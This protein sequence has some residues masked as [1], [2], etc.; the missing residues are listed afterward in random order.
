M[1]RDEN[2]ICELTSCVCGGGA[3]DH[4]YKN[5]GVARAAHTELRDDYFSCQE[6]ASEGRL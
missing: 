2:E 4:A 6:F 1:I 3:L 5:V